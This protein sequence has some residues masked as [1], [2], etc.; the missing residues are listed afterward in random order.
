MPAA[1]IRNKLWLHSWHGQE[2]LL[3]LSLLESAL[4]PSYS[5]LLMQRA[6]MQM[7]DSLI[8]ALF[9]S[10]GIQEPV[11]LKCVIDLAMLEDVALSI[12]SVLT[13]LAKPE[14]SFP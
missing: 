13:V 12:P 3:W 6:V 10:T 1:R 14:L 8:Y 4:T 11:T 7:L 2:L 9:H 5:G